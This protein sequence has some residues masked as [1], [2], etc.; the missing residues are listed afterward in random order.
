MDIGKLR[1][2]LHSKKLHYR[3]FHGCHCHHYA[4]GILIMSVMLVEGLHVL[5][6]EQKAT[7]EVTG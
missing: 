3:E 2:L 7:N 1:F 5:L 4:T 6:P